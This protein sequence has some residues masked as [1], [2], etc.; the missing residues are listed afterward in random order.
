M[1]FELAKWY[2]TLRRSIARSLP[3]LIPGVVCVLFSLPPLLFIRSGSSAERDVQM[4]IGIVFL[5]ASI[6]LL[7]VWI[8]VIASICRYN[9][10]A[11]LHDVSD[12]EYDQMIDRFLL[13]LRNTRAMQVL[14]I[15]ASEVQEIR[16]LIFGGYKILGANRFKRGKDGLYRTDV[17][18]AVIIYFS[19]NEV[20][21]YTCNFHTTKNEWSEAT[22]VY[23]Y[24]D[25]V[26]VS[27]ILETV[28]IGTKEQPIQ[29]FS[30]TTSGGTQL[31][32]SLNKK[33]DTD[34]SINAMRSLLREKKQ[35][36]A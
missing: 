36:M 19:A 3:F 11:E 5:I 24:R 29:K 10:E 4:I 35:S 20:H 8:A 34:R 2:F 13:Q 16:P 32:V 22:D 7:I 30:L 1:D 17:Y 14:G 26:S 31:S 33:N 21:C 12:Q 9:K 23:F 15:D 25:V 27:T 28:K 6:V 18:E